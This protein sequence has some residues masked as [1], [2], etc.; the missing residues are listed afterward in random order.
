[1]KLFGHT[2]YKFVDEQQVYNA[3]Y[4]EAVNEYNRLLAERIALL[5]KING[6]SVKVRELERRK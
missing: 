3:K 1:M 5:N 6:L 4:L 2:L